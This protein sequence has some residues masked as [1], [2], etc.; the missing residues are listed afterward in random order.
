MSVEI[1]W[2]VV[3]V[4]VMGGMWWVAYK[5]EPHWSSKDGK[6]FL[7]SA[8]EIVKGLPEGRPRETRVMVMPDGLLHVSVKRMMRRHHSKWMLVGR[9]PDPPKKLQI[10]LAQ[11]REDG[12][13]LPMMLSLRIPA[14]SRCVAVL[15]S[16][17]AA[18]EV[19]A[20]RP[21]PGTGRPAGRP[22]PG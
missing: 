16:L 9:S 10:Y 20:S 2:L 12:Q 13:N 1:F 4:A 18:S 21:D 19:R 5:M 7:C 3:L 15:D 11:M 8:Q 17:L 22:D 6:R 14:G